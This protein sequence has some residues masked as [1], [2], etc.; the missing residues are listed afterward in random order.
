MKK[1]QRTEEKAELD[2]LAGSSK[3]SPKKAFVTPG[4]NVSNGS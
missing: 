1:E 2:D 3:V 4:D